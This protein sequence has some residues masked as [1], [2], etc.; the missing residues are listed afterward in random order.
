[1]NYTQLVAPNLDP[2]VYQNGAALTDWLGWCLAVAWTAFGGKTTSPTAWSAWT[3][4]VQFKHT[5]SLPTGVY[6]P[7]W[8]SG[9]GGSGHVAIYKD[10]T[11]WSSPYTHKS[12]MDVLSSIAQLEKYYGVTYVGWSEDIGGVRVVQ[13]I[14]EGEDMPNEGDVHNAY[15]KANGRQATDEEVKT[16]TSKPWS[17]PDGLLY[18]KIFVDLESFKNTVPT[19]LKPYAGPQLYTK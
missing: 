7:V 12:S 11:V 16:Y 19:D 1:M 18:G 13:P 3:N 2:V 10:G 8:F 5:D 6:V 9:Y 17:A 14:T 15:L 4:S